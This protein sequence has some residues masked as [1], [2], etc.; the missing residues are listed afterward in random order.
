MYHDKAARPVGRSVLR[1]V[2]LC[3]L[4]NMFL[5]AV[6]WATVRTRSNL[7]TQGAKAVRQAVMSAAVQ[8]YAVE[9]VYPPTLDYLEDNYGL[10]INHNHY[11]VTYEAF[12][13]NLPPEVA[14]LEK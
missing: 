2:V 9:G 7:H 1:A 14:V 5:A 13:S 4:L 12:A 11:I 3:V 8:C 10:Q 6:L